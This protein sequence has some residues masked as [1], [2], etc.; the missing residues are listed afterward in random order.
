MLARREH[1]VLLDELKMSGISHD[2]EASGGY[3]SD[4]SAHASFKGELPTERVAAFWPLHA[5]PK[6]HHAT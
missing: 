6:P 5:I 3:A 4:G 1:R 2:N